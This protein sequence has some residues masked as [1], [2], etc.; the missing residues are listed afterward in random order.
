M[1]CSKPCL[2]ATLPGTQTVSLPSQGSIGSSDPHAFAIRFQ[3]NAALGSWCTTGSHP[4]TRV[5]PTRIE[6]GVSIE[7]IDTHDPSQPSGTSTD[8]NDPPHV[9]SL[10][11]TS[12][13]SGS[14]H[15]AGEHSHGPHALN[16]F[17]P[18]YPS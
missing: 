14:S 15:V 1:H 7:P 13:S 2:G 9:P 16:V 6:V 10:V 8:C 5:G 12:T 4:P 3:V 17:S 18:A 11:L